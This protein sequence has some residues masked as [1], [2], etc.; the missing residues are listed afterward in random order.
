MATAGTGLTLRHVEVRRSS[1]DAIDIGSADD[2]TIVDSLVHHALNADDGRT[3]AHGIVAAAVHRLTIRNTQVHTFSGDA[4]QV[5]PG[6][7]APGWSDILIEGCDLWLAPLPAA[8]NG[9][10]AGTV[11]GENAVDTKANPG[12]ARATL[13]IRD[14]RAHGFRNG[15]IPNMAAFNLK[16]NVDVLVDRITV[17]DSEIAFRLR[18]GG[19]DTSKPGAHVR[20]MNALVY[21]TAVAFRYEDDLEGL[22]VWNSTIG[23]GV[24]RPFLECGVEGLAR[25]RAERAR[26][27]RHEGP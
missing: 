14:T 3:D 20:T 4:I 24:P 11:P 10:A 23:R 26:P 6:R 1:R 18:G 21:D 12:M 15:L 19:S 7:S 8:V 17:Y 25:R 22:H 16:E 2:V 5:D 13:T 9:F 27:G